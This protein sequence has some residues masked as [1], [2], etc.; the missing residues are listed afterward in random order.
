MV[1]Y[2][3]FIVSGRGEFPIDMLRYDECFPADGASASIITSTL[4]GFN[5]PKAWEVKLRTAR[6][7]GPAVDRWDSFNCKVREI[8]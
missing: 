8:A 6:T 1:K 5:A 4:T 2:Q 7:F 3:D